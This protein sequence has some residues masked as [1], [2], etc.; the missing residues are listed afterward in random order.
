MVAVVA[1]SRPSEC[2]RDRRHIMRKLVV[3]LVVGMLL[4]TGCSDPVTPG[5]GQ[6]GEAVIDSY[7]GIRDTA[8]EVKD[9]VEATGEGL[10]IET[11]ESP[12]PSLWDVAT[13]IH[14][15]D[16]YNQCLDACETGDTG[17]ERNCEILWAE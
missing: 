11:H 2:Y 4:I 13:E 16:Q 1:V 6:V 10:E 12:L 9:A 8:S 3:V 5:D 17:C 15:A 14:S 7:N